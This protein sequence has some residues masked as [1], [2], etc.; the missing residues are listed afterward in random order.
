LFGDFYQG[1]Q[2]VAKFA[3]GFDRTTHLIFPRKVIS[4]RRPIVPQRLH[5]PKQISP[6]SEN[7]WA[8]PLRGL[9]CLLN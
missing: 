6:A 9:A 8:R 3:R 7:A 2:V 1:V 5:A 4:A